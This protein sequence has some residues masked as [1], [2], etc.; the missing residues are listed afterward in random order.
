[1]AEVRTIISV[2]QQSARQVADGLRQA[3]QQVASVAGRTVETEEGLEIREGTL[4]RI[5]RLAMAQY[6]AAMAEAGTP[7]VEGTTVTLPRF[8]AIKTVAARLME[9][10]EIAEEDY[11][12][13]SVNVPVMVS[14]PEEPPV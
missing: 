4:Q 9:L 7:V 10:I 1:M 11:T 2:S 14:E 5:E 12:A 8:S 3:R 6:E 13:R